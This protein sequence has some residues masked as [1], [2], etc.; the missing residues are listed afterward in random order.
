[1]RTSRLQPCKHRAA[2]HLAHRL[3]QCRCL[4]TTHPARI[5]TSRSLPT[6][7]YDYDDCYRCCYCYYCFCCRGPLSNEQPQEA[8]ANQDHPGERLKPWAIL[9][10]RSGLSAR[11]GIKGSRFRAFRV[12]L[13]ALALA[14][15]GWDLGMLLTVGIRS[16]L[17]CASLHN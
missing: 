1:M 6:T 5:V 8:N 3:S 15:I 2:Q 11:S 16:I 13:L 12:L 14:D 10:P 17:A 7:D 9:G 4:R